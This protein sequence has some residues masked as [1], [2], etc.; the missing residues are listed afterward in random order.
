MA[1]NLT[2]HDASWVSQFIASRRSTRDFLSTKVPQKLIDQLLTDALTAPS[3][4]N[5][6]PFKIAVA[7][8]EVRDRISNEFLSRWGVL[9]QIMRKG[10]KNKL[11]LIYSRYGLPTSNRSIVKPYVAELRPRA[12]RVGKE[13]YGLFGVKRGDRAARDAQWGKNYSFFG[14]PVEMFIYIHKSLHV[15]A[16]SD[17]GL[18][19]ENLMLSAHAHGLGTCAQGAVNIWD[20]VIRREFDVPKDYRLLCG[21]AIGF[22]S[23]APVNSF[24][25]N[26]IPPSE[27]LLKAKNSKN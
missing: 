10:I 5:T 12:Q 17:A 14:A 18:M 9:S 13:L 19:M 25:A 6:R 27:I 16:A 23:D 2:D 24:R 26:R 21:L 7:T 22:P 11:R 15:Y 4:S 3:W 20:D 8:D 1:S